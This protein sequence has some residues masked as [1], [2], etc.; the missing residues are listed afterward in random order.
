MRVVCSCSYTRQEAPYFIPMETSVYIWQH[1]CRIVSGDPYQISF[2]RDYC[3][4]IQ[5]YRL[6]LRSQSRPRRLEV[7]AW[8]T[9]D[10][11]R[12]RHLKR[13]RSLRLVLRYV[14]LR[15][16][17]SFVVCLGRSSQPTL[18]NYLEESCFLPIRSE[19]TSLVH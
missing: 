16:L 3:V 6:Q 10:L 12:R 11:R 4:S 8:G 17:L 15:R 14:W 19:K 13:R 7:L 2:Q 5:K 9:R 18:P 1:N